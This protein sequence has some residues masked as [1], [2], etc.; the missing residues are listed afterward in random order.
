M[1]EI[2]LVF[3]IYAMSD[4]F[5][6]YKGT[7]NGIYRQTKADLWTPQFATILLLMLGILVVTIFFNAAVFSFGHWLI[8]LIVYSVEIIIPIVLL[9]LHDRKIHEIVREKAY[10]MDAANPGI[11][12]AYEEWRSN[13]NNLTS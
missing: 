7:I 8:S 1:D 3:F 2:T 10:Q 6:K 13:I 4:N 9:Y 12:E 11:S 5:E